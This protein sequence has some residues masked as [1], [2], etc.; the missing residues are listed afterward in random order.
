MPINETVIARAGYYRLCFMKIFNQPLETALH[1]LT[2]TRAY[3]L[4]LT[5]NFNI[6]HPSITLHDYK[7]ARLKYVIPTGM[8]ATAEKTHGDVGM[9]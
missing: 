1:R 3:Y 5:A 4:V 2:E 7:N 6:N 8:T 9:A